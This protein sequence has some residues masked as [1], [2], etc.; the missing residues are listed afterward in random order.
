MKNQT[1]DHEWRKEWL[2]GNESSLNALVQKYHTEIYSFLFYLSFGNCDR[3]YDMTVA[4]FV[5]AF[6]L[7]KRKD[8]AFLTTLFKFAVEQASGKNFTLQKFPDP[9]SAKL[10]AALQGLSYE[11]KIL[12]L[13]RYQQRFSY[14]MMGEVLN[15]YPDEIKLPLTAAKKQFREKLSEQLN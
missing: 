9:K 5:E 10:A 12:L 4:A 1:E 2:E 11:Y 14:R 6:G 13:L 7:L 8:G 15:R 3:A